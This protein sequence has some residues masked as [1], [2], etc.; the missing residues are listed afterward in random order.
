MWASDFVCQLC[1]ARLPWA[2]EV[3]FQTVRSVSCFLTLSNNLGHLLFARR[4]T[5]M[6]V[7]DTVA[8]LSQTVKPRSVVETAIDPAQIATGRET[9]ERFIHGGATA[10]IG[11]VGRVQTEPVVHSMCARSRSLDPPMVVQASPV[12]NIHHFSGRPWVSETAE[13]P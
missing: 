7:S 8:C 12:R 10:N 6:I 1:A 3:P 4:T 13:I 9:L 2:R 11:K 5:P